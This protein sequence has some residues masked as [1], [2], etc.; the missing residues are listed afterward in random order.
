M[1][2][3]RTVVC[4]ASLLLLSPAGSAQR[5][6]TAAGSAQEDVINTFA[7]GGPNNVPATSANVPNPVAV[8]IDSSGNYYFATAQWL[9][10]RVY[11]VSTSG[12]LTVF[13]GNGFPGDGGDGGPAPQAELDYPGGVAL[14]SSGNMYIAD[15]DNCAI[16]KVDTSGTI[17]TFAGTLGSCG[18]GGDGGPATSA[19]LNLPEGVAVD[20]S[21]NVFISDFA[22]YRIREVRASNGDINTVAGTGTKCTGGGAACGDGGL[23]TSAGISDVY[24]LAVDGFGNVYIADYNNYEIR[25]FSVGGNISA[26][27]GNGTEGYWGDGGAATSA[28]LSYPQAVAADSPGNI[29][30]ADDGNERIR[31]VTVSNG[32]INT[33][34]GNG[35]G[36]YD[37]SA[38]C[39]DGGLATSAELSW[40]YGLAVDSSDNIFIA[41]YDNYRIR[42]V[43]A[44]NGY[45]KRMAGNGTS[46]FTGNGIPATNAALYSPVAATSDSA[47]NIYIADQYNCIVREVH[48]TTGII[49][50]LAGTPGFCAYGGDRGP[51]TSAYLYWPSKV[52]VYGDNVYI[53]DMANYVIRKVDPSGTIT[54][55]A[56]TPLCCGYSGD[57][58][59][60]TRACLGFDLGVAVDSSG[61]V[62]IGDGSNHRVR[63][64][65]VSHGIINTVAG[66][67]TSG[68]SGDG[69]PATS[70]DLSEPVDVALDARGNLYIADYWNNRIRKVNTRGIIST[71]AGGGSTSG[72]GGPANEAGL[73]D[74]S[75]VAVDAAGDVLIA[76]YGGGHIRWVDGQGIIHTVAGTGGYGFS[77]DGGLGSSAM[78]AWPQGVGVDP[79]GNIYVADTNN[80]RVRRVNA[81]AALN[82][83]TTSL[84]FG[85]QPVG[86]SSSPQTVT[87][88]AIGPLN[89]N[90]IVVTGDFTESDDCG[91]GPVSGQCVMRIVFKPTAA[92]TCTG[93]VTI[94]DNGYFSTALV[95]ELKG[96]G[97]WARP[98]P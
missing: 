16:R 23:A 64:V 77:G 26:A 21:G 39:G 58:G 81:V 27:A 53:A 88:S 59:P 62:Y 84:T 44:S 33:V 48:A 36:C 17:S 32:I 95:I 57:G 40:V 54:T 31:E 86:M 79:S 38:A 2:Q 61:D 34:A 46:N 82:A 80:Y 90:D 28:E 76:D 45:I 87:L 98:L 63:E 93:T 24:S 35:T 37:P 65:T 13:A 94:R 22:N 60:A 78:L 41:D 9:V 92:G 56:G 12:T 50:T 49:T 71:F 67:G 15:L 4:L 85:P 8:A 66:T 42:E 14:D 72:D 73:S 29:F 7:G 52:A 11:K 75:G 1:C 68:Y 69:G 91:T 18:Y 19:Y 5:V 20:K 83:S 30:I 47:G 70:A 6:P 97:I 74:P 25:K 10:N 96:T 55:F 43:T 51:A 89:I 3:L